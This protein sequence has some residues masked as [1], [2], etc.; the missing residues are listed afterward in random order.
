MMGAATP[1]QR[2]GLRA[3]YL[4]DWSRGDGM[5][6]EGWGKEVVQTRKFGTACR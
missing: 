4:V 3:G 5:Y 2:E 1:G 6:D